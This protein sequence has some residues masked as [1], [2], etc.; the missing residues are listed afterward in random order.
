MSPRRLRKETVVRPHTLTPKSFTRPA[1]LRRLQP[2]SLRPRRARLIAT[3]LALALVSVA[4]ALLLAARAEDDKPL[5]LSARMWE[6]AEAPAAARPGK[7]Q[8]IADVATFVDQIK[9]TLVR[10]TPREAENS[11]STAGFERAVVR[12]Y[13]ADRAGAA[14]VAIQLRDT[15]AAT[16]VLDWSKK[17]AL[18]P[19]PGECN[20]DISAFDVRQIP[21]AS[22]VQRVRERGAKG[23]GPSHAFESYEISFVDGHVLYVL[24]TEGDPGTVDRNGLV[25]AAKQLYARVRGRPLP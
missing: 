24:R 12:E 2:G 5:A 4:A 10:A 9:D 11:L 17:D 18:S 22:G 15:D 3:A 23:A 7:R 19:C 16:S 1:A 14:S 21:E 25:H 13:E 8:A 20:V 6:P